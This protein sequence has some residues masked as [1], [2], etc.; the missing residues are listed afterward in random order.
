MARPTVRA[1]TAQD[2]SRQAMHQVGHGCAQLGRLPDHGGR[3]GS[4][5][6]CFKWR[7]QLLKGL[8]QYVT[9][10]SVLISL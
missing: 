5:P 3:V 9:L 6:R 10:N 4:G 8:T 2:K 7:G 1:N